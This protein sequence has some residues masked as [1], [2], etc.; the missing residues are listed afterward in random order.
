MMHRQKV[1]LLLWFAT[2]LS[3]LALVVVPALA[4]G[5]T[6]TVVKD[7]DGTGTVTSDP[8]GINCGAVCDVTFTIGKSRMLATG[9]Q[10]T[11]TAIPDEGS[12]F[13]AWGQDCV[14]TQ[15]RSR[16]G[17]DAGIGPCNMTLTGNRTCTATFGLPVGGIAVPVNKLGLVAPWLG[18]AALASLA[19]LTVAV[20]RRRRG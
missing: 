11:L 3:V 20:V 9:V 10:V 13:A 4:N 5:S 15:R 2:L 1:K 18:V 7:G 12:V 6:L 16:V 8:A 17:F 19:A 14:C